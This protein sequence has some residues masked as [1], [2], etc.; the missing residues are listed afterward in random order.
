M[1]GFGIKVI[2]LTQNKLRNFPYFAILSNSLCISGHIYHLN[3]LIELTFKI[4]WAKGL[5]VS[6]WEEA[7]LSLQIKIL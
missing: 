3:S 4:I 2:L 5:S 6:I 7:D 1:S